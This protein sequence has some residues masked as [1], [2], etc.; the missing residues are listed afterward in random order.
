LLLRSNGLCIA[1][2]G[3]RIYSGSGAGRNGRCIGAADVDIGVNTCHRGCGGGIAFVIVI[4][5][6]NV[7]AA[8]V[9]ACKQQTEYH[10]TNTKNQSQ[11]P[12][13]IAGGCCFCCSFLIGALRLCR[14]LGGGCTSFLLCRIA[15]G[16]TCIAGLIGCLTRAVALLSRRFGLLLCHIQNSVYGVVFSIHLLYDNIRQNTRVIYTI[17]K[18]DKTLTFV[19]Y[20]SLS[21]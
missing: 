5:D 19:Y 2:F 16:L 17:K 11:S 15:A 10:Q 21:S 12:E 20:R 7:F 8:A 3:C 4:G 9:D 14:L 18:D 1:A 6:T 13:N